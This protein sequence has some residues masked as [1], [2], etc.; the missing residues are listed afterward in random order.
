MLDLALLRTIRLDRRPLS[1]RLIADGFLRF[2]YRKVDLV[3]EGLETLPKTP[4]I[5]AMNHTDNFNYW[6]F[7]YAM[8]RRFARYTATWVK[9]KNFENPF[10]S[11]FMAAT[12]NIPVASRGYLV[13][14]DFVATIKRRPTELEYRA[15]RDALDSGTEVDP[16]QVPREL[17]STPRDLFGR[18]FD[19]SKERY[20]QA[21]DA[22]LAALMDGFVELN[23]HALSIGLD[24]LVFPEG[25][26][27]LRLSKGHSGIAQVALHLG[28]T[29]VPIGC[30]GSN[31]VY[32][33]NSFMAKPGRIVYRLG[34]PMTPDRFADLAPS[35]PFVPFSREADA[36]HE[37][38]FQA[39]TD[40]VMDALDPLLDPEY[41]RECRHGESKGSVGTHRFL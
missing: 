38:S 11:R 4:V 32:P 30:S 33:G 13:T 9:G 25:S 20:D 34:E 7:Q 14:R 1:Q 17:L 5:Y 31:R 28:A 40:R 29:I 35:V 18:R 23:R 41:R 39:V 22:V 6:P 27:S 24:V 3:L 37:S 10:V 12:N 2:D 16:A 19:P 26:R 15:L 21:V 8:H 36:L